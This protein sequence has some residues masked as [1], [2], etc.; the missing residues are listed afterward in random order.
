MRKSLYS[1]LRPRVQRAKGNQAGEHSHERLGVEELTQYFRENWLF[2][3][4]PVSG[5]VRIIGEWFLTTFQIFFSYSF[6]AFFKPK[7]PFT[8]VGYLYRYNAALVVGLG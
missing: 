4:I 8:P 6:I 1:S 7:G 5:L 2:S 3:P